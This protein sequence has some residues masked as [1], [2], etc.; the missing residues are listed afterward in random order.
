MG[1]SSRHMAPDNIQHRLQTIAQGYSAPLLPSYQVHFFFQ[2]STETLNE[3]L[4]NVSLVSRVIRY[5]TAVIA[6]ESRHIEKC[7]LGMQPLSLI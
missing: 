6:G 4:L 1:A 5:P 7:T 2:W 3:T